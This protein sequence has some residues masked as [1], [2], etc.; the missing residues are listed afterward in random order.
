MHAAMIAIMFVFNASNKLQRVGCTVVFKV[1]VPLPFLLQHGNIRV[2]L[3]LASV[4]DEKR[5]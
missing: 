2:W 4:M 1:S 5:N 3:A